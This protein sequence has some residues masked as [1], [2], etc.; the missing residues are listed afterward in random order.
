[1]SAWKGEAMSITIT[2][3]GRFTGRFLEMCEEI[4][5]AIADASASVVVVK[6]LTRAELETVLSE[7]QKCE[8]VKY[9]TIDEVVDATELERMLKVVE[10]KKWK[11]VKREARNRDRGAEHTFSMANAKRQ[12]AGDTRSPSCAGYRRPVYRRRR[13]RV[14]GRERRREALVVQ[15]LRGESNA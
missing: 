14:S 15:V 6:G 7:A 9:I 2:M 8:A 13:S 3:T 10:R 5:H 12:H 4:R 1:V 11:K